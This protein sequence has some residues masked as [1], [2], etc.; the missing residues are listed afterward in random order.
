MDAGGKEIVPCIYIYIYM[1]YVLH[2]EE[3]FRF[4]FDLFLCDLYF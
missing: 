3:D 4:F 1:F 2:F